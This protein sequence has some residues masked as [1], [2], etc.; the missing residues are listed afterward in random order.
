MADA[1]APNRELLRQSTGSI[2]LRPSR[3]MLPPPAFTARPRQH[4]HRHHHAASSR[5]AADQLRAFAKGHSVTRFVDLL[6]TLNKPTA[7]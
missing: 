5:S 1:A 6:G 3:T 2:N 4:H 7:G